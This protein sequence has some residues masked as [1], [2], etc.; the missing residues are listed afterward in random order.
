MRE[1]FIVESPAECADRLV[2]EP[3]VRVVAVCSRATECRRSAEA[4]VVGAVLALLL[5]EWL[6]G[7]A[8][9]VGHGVRRLRLRNGSELFALPRARAE[10]LLAGESFRYVWPCPSGIELDAELRAAVQPTVDDA[11]LIPHR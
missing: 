8:L 3:G 4:V 6:P 11:G 7:S 9:T 2:A 10:R 5:P 1:G